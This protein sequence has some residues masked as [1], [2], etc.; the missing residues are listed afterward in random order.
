MTTQD[1]PETSGVVWKTALRTAQ[2]LILI[3][4]PLLMVVLGV[5]LS[6]HVDQVSELLDLSLED[7]WKVFSAW[8]MSGVLGFLV[9]FSARTLFAFKWEK[10]LGSS[11]DW[12]RAG[13]WLPR[14]LGMLV[15]LTL[16]YAYA[17][18]PRSASCACAWAW[19]FV[20]QGG[21]VLLL[22]WKRRPMLRWL[23]LRL[24]RD[25]DRWAA[26]NPAVGS[27]TNWKQLGTIRY[28]HAVGLLVFIVAALVGWLVPESIKV[29]GPLGLILGAAAWLV[30]AS[31]AP[32]YWAAVRQVPLLT[33]L[34]LWAMLLASY[35][36]NDNHAVRLS[37]DM[38]SQRDPPD[39]LRY[40]AAGR[41]TLSGFIE[42]WLH[43]HPYSVC[44]RI[45]L[46]ASEGGGIRA[47]AWTSVVLS[48]LDRVSAGKLWQCTLAV[49]GVSGGSLGLALYAAYQRDHGNAV[50]ATPNAATMETLVTGDYLEPV[51]GSMFGVDH[52]Q[53]FVPGRWFPDRGQA[54]EDAWIAAY[55]RT[56][57]PHSFAGSLAA[58]LTSGNSNQHLPALLLNSTVVGTG[59]RLIQHP[60]QPMRELAADSREILRPHAPFADVFPGAV[61]GANWLPVEL[62]L[63]S[64]ALNSARFTYVSPAGT[65]R[66]EVSATGKPRT[67]GQLVDGGY[68]ENSGATTLGDFL[69][70]ALKHRRAEIERRVSIIHISNDPGVAAFMLRRQEGVPPPDQC[71]TNPEPKPYPP[72]NAATHGEVL[73]PV[74]A[75]Y[76]ARE[77]RGEQAR[78][79]LL[80]Q[81][82]TLDQDAPRF[83]H[84]RLCPSTPRIP[85][86]WTIGNQ[87]IAQMRSQLAG[88]AT[89]HAAGIREMVNEA[90][91]IPDT[92]LGIEQHSQPRVDGQAR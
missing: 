15:P 52:L 4:I 41:P 70:F 50:K 27:Y 64:A 16:A 86:G 74:M 9:W 39:G 10:R 76:Q 54:L 69:R 55:A 81:A 88:E 60:F 79:S 20:A 72:R 80:E 92:A 78:R 19:L 8:L 77:A 53:R 12:H 63:S 82:V 23:A 91:A 30:W 3:R 58:T 7:F 28:W 18:R 68:F 61:D 5:V 36:L 34:G 38:S 47:T 65:V 29:L 59:A 71:V 13:E 6:R 17:S 2:L 35:G 42:G 49:S 33:F 1:Q 22:T 25:P 37:P 85:L 45:Y 40:D 89:W 87:T 44:P 84:F 48:E 66:R 11:A 32:V 73:S 51:L 31:T 26:V 24:G 57:H 83:W 67:L 90:M 62:P 56:D 75:L 43:D 46:I 21:V 14:I